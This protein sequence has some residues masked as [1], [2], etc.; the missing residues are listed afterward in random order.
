[1]KCPC[2]GK[3][4]VIESENGTFTVYC[5]FGPC[6]STT[7][8]N[9]ASGESLFEAFSVFRGMVEYEMDNAP[10]KEMSPDV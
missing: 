8:N 2:C 4:V 10:T 6:K 3:P 7:S 1:M 5:S 9:G